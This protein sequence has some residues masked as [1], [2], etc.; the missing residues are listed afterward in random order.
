[1][2]NQIMCI[3]KCKCKYSENRELRRS[4]FIK[5]LYF[6]LLIYC[7]IDI[8]VIKQYFQYLADWILKGI[9]KGVKS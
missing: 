2:C 6:F 1:M 3:C 8:G 7:D 5:V 9:N 4:L